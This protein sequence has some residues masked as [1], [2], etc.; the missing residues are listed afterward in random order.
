MLKSKSEEADFLISLEDEL[1]TSKKEAEL[2]R[3]YNALALSFCINSIRAWG[4][5]FRSPSS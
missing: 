5:G 1:S 3:Y 2:N 4:G